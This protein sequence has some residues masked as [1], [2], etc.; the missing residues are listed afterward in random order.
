MCL[1]NK[2]KI[3]YDPVIL[4]TGHMEDDVTLSE[5]PADLCLLA[6]VKA[7]KSTQ[8]PSHQWVSGWMI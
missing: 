7:M 8:M 6:T 4:T 5:M 1:Q 2:N 3:Q